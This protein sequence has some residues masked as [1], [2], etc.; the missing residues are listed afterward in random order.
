VSGQQNAPTTLYSREI[1]GTYFTGGW[2]GPRAGLDG[3]KISY[4]PGFDRGPSNAWSV[5]IP[6][7]LPGPQL[8]PYLFIIRSVYR[9]ACYPHTDQIS[10]KLRRRLSRT[11][12]DFE[13]AFDTLGEFPDSPDL[14]RY[15]C[16]GLRKLTYS[17]RAWSI[18]KQRICLALSHYFICHHIFVCWSQINSAH[19][20]KSRETRQYSSFVSEVYCCC[21][22]HELKNCTLVAVATAT[23]I[24]LL[25]KIGYLYKP[26][27]CF[28]LV[29]FNNIWS[30]YSVSLKNAAQIFVSLQFL[31]ATRCLA[32]LW[33]CYESDV[34]WTVH[35]CD[36][37]R[38]K[39]PTRYHL[40][41]YC[42]SYR[43]NMFRALLFQSSGTRDYDVVYHI[44][45][46]V[47]GLLYVGG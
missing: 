16:W 33:A 18:T 24:W 41:F 28:K 34:Y 43:L 32:T 22:I 46:V 25:H 12:L 40:V 5:A 8:Y 45:R 23:E 37:W 7:E 13:A 15:P 9:I 17:T 2:V 11:A 6:T 26:P 47:L 42:T 20:C 39:K 30:M 44:G 29:S 10:P 19:N 4:P 35:H 31:T 36:N 27:L 38:I 21:Y 3:R 1:P 14:P